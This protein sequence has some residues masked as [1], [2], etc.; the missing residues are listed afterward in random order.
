MD[1][2]FETLKKIVISVLIFYFILFLIKTDF[3]FKIL[4]I[5]IKFDPSRYIL[6]ILNMQ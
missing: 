3:L 4:D 5:K 1:N 2:A 6:E